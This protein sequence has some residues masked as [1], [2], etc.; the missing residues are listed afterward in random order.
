MNIYKDNLIEK[1]G[2]QS[3]YDFVILRYCEKIQ[4]NPRLTY[5]FDEFS[6][7]DLMKLQKQLL[8]AAFLKLRSDEAEAMMGRLS[9]QYHKLWRMGLNER[10]YEV[11]KGHFLEALRECWVEEGLIFL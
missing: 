3:H 10:Y 7:D 2:G 5:F 8:D 4:N 1:V 9:L 6:L 11:M